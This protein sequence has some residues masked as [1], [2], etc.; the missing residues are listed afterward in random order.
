M[1]HWI[2]VEKFKLKHFVG[3]CLKQMFAHLTECFHN[4]IRHESNFQQLCTNNSTML[5][6]Y[7]RFV[8]FSVLETEELTH[9]LTI[10]L[11]GFFTIFSYDSIRFFLF[12][13]FEKA[14]LFSSYA[15]FVKTN[16]KYLRLYRM[17]LQSVSW[18]WYFSLISRPS[19]NESK[20]WTTYN[21]IKALRET[22]K[23]NGKG[24]NQMKE[25][26]EKN[27]LNDFGGLS[28]KLR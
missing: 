10:F 14:K 5:N 7:F 19:R 4:K 9:S 15:Q 11:F 21:V 22:T 23:T 18:H 16:N 12:F 13:F 28:V 17:D 3:M 8:L 2:I 25:H 1:L 6:F 24:T 20:L 27:V 26:K